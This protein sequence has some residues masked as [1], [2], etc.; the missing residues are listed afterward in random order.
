MSATPKISLALL[1]LATLACSENLTPY[2]PDAGSEVD[3]LECLPNLDGLLERSEMPT[4]LATPVPYLIARNATIDLSSTEL[5]FRAELAGEEK[6]NISALPISDQWYADEFPASSIVVALGADEDSFGVLESSDAAIRLLGIVSAQPDHTLLHYQTPIDLY[7]FPITRGS[8]WSSSS[9]VT[10]TLAAVPYNGTDTYDVTVP[11]IDSVSLP[12]LRF[13]Q[14]YR[15]HTEVVSD[16]GAA[17]VVVR[18]QQIS[19]ISE[20]FGEITRAVSQDD[21]T[22]ANFSSAAELWRF[23]L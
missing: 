22:A 8:Q 12:H 21:E 13:T 10:G 17:G 4:Q 6:R 23:S 14:A 18:R 15:V 1:C 11:S 9:S 20:C 16:S 19:L 2:G 3:L 5:D 7:R